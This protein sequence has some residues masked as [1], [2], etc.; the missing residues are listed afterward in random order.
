MTAKAPPASGGSGRSYA[1]SFGKTCGICGTCPAPYRVMIVPP[2]LHIRLGI[3]YERT[4]DA[5]MDCNE[6]AR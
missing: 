2:I 5:C 1:N 3:D 4:V 6:E